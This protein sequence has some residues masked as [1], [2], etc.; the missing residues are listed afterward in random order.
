MKIRQK[1]PTS[2]LID[3]SGLLVRPGWMLAGLCLA[4]AAKAIGPPFEAFYPP[5]AEPFG[6]GWSLARFLAS[7]WAV[8]LVL[9][10][11][12]G[13][14]LGDLKGR[15]RVL[16]WSLAVMLIADIALL[17]SP[18]TLWHVLWRL[19]A[20]LSAGIIIP[21]TLAPLYIFFT[22]R[23]RA[24]AFAIYLTIFAISEFLSIYQG[25]LFI[26]LLDWRGAYL[27]PAASTFVAI[28]IVRRSLPESRT[29]NPRTLQAVFY[30]GW[31]ILVLGILYAVVELIL[32]RRWLN[33]VILINGIM[34]VSGLGL[35]YWWWRKEKPD[36]QRIQSGRIRPVMILILSGVIL[37]IAFLGFYSLTYSYYR[38]AHNLDFLQ[39]LLAMSPMFLG[40]LATTF[41]VVRLW[42]HRSIRHVITIGF[43]LVASAITAMGIVARLPYWVQ[44]LPL[45]VFGISIIATKTIWTNA[46]F[47]I[48]IDR[49]IGLNA[50][51]NSATLLVGG[52][53]GGVVSTELLAMFGQSAF[54]RQFSSLT[55]SEG[56]VNSLFDS[57]S[58]S[59]ATW[60][61]LGVN[62]LS[63]AISSR[64]YA[65]YQ[66]AYSVGYTLTVLVISLLC[67]LAA[68][69]IYRGIRRSMV[70][71]P[72]DT[73]INDET[74]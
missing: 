16:L 34:L 32:G 24:I 48:L 62:N 42:A 2:Q 70:F 38:V 33:V 13:G 49:Y 52:A 12:G 71:K 9:F 56:V 46:F 18:N 43:L 63:S 65:Q 68:V 21:L 29:A 10:M 41:F 72:E 73:P 57:I 1:I 8:L 17:F 40:L 47:Q 14:I 59:V 31:T 51:M 19:P 11:L 30:A 60:E 54:V 64:F 44:I 35:I 45:A 69:I 27:I 53:L 25:R 66:E 4:G 58:A 55:I 23:Q 22:G 67:L 7:S 15:R 50:G 36:A 20:N 74:N 3:D 26:Q 39:T 5:G 28:V 6:A 37:Q 61:N